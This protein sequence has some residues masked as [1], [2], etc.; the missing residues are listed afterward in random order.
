MLSRFLYEHGE[1]TV[2]DVQS[3]NPDLE[4]PDSEVQS[5]SPLGDFVQRLAGTFKPGSTLTTTSAADWR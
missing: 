2:M 3:I 5:A 4:I 1:S